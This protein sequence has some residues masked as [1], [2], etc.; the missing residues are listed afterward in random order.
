MPPGTSC[1]YIRVFVVVY[2]CMCSLGS[3]YNSHIQKSHY[4]IV[5]GLQL[6]RKSESACMVSMHVC[7]Y[8]RFA[9]LG[10]VYPY[11]LLTLRYQTY[12]SVPDYW[13]K[14]T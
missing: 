5:C 13:M 11:I 10:C 14:E 6:L 1:I 2:L 9:Q 4:I 8:C 3:G 12:A 7:T